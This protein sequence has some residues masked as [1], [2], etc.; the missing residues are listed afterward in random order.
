M[1]GFCGYVRFGRI[2]PGLARRT[3]TKHVVVRLT[4]C[5]ASVALGF[6]P[7]GRTSVKVAVISQSANNWPLFVAE[8]KGFFQREGLQVEVVVSGDSGRQIDGLI[9]GT[10]DITHQASDHFMAR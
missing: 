10:Y 1:T 6:S 3:P 8:E 4:N 7:G 5:R 2:L 9:N